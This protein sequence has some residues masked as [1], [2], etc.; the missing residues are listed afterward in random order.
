MQAIGTIVSGMWCR[1]WRNRII[2]IEACFHTCDSDSIIIV[3]TVKTSTSWKRWKRGYGERCRC[4]VGANMPLR[5]VLCYVDPYKFSF[6]LS[7]N[8]FNDSNHEMCV[9][10]VRYETAVTMSVRKFAVRLLAAQRNYSKYHY[11]HG[12]IGS[13]PEH[14]VRLQCNRLIKGT[15]YRYCITG[16]NFLCPAR[17]QPSSFW[18]IKTLKKTFFHGTPELSFSLFHHHCMISTTLKLAFTRSQCCCPGVKHTPGQCFLSVST[19]GNNNCDNLCRLSTP[20][21]SCC[22]CVLLHVCIQ[23]NMFITVAWSLAALQR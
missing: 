15:G 12:T 18:A 11:S 10:N 2:C 9:I 17:K 21:H 4:R 1:V 5:R 7:A 13:H 23:F 19:T 22:N 16:D 20:L 6:S 14:R 8:S 3:V